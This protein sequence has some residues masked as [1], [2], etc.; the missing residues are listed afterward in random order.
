MQMLEKIK[1]NI[2]SSQ[3]K[4]TFKKGLIYMFFKLLKFFYSM[5]VNLK[6]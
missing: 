4:R 6:L 3:V 1:N 2:F 5:I